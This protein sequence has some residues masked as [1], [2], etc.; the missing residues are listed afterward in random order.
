MKKS[1]F[2]CR[3]AKTPSAFTLLELLICIA[4]IALLVG[5]LFPVSR[6]LMNSALSS[7]C[8]SNLRQIG[9]ALAAYGAD[10]EGAVPPR[11]LGLNRT[12]EPKPPSNLRSWPA[13]L[14]NLGYIDDI[15]VFFC[16]SFLPKNS[17][18][19][20][21]DLRVSGAADTYGMRTWAPRN[22][23]GSEY[24]KWAEEEKKLV[25]I[26]KPSD[27][28]LVADS[29]WTEWG[30]QGY[31]ITPGVMAQSV[32]LRHSDRANALFADGHVEAKPK[33][34][35]SNLHFTDTQG[36][37]SNGNETRLGAEIY[38]TPALVP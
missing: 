12:T 36:P 7:K 30:T 2:A 1:R 29:Y 5:L 4:V 3:P 24:Q 9:S 13:R 10:S 33:E 38:T 37:Y 18:G 11:N 14:V 32:H 6:Q 8:A 25:F 26:E 19:A 21:S 27:F 31:G 16:P 20:R 28:F 17:A 23:R 15:N 35:F 34:Y 22:A